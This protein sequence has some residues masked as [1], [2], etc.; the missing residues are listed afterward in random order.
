MALELLRYQ[1]RVK[2]EERKSNKESKMKKI[3]LLQSLVAAIA[4]ATSVLLASSVWAVS[5]LDF[6]MAA[7]T[8]G[9]ISY[10]GGANPLSGVN[11]QVDTITGLSTPLNGGS[12]VACVGCVLSFSTGNFS[13]ANGTTVWNFC[14]GGTISVIGGVDLNGGGLGA[15]DIAAGTTLLSGTVTAGSV[16]AATG[17]FKVSIVSFNDVKDPD[18]AA[19]FGMLGG[20]GI[21]WTGNFNLS[22]NATGA[23]PS[24]FTSTSILSGDI[25]NERVP[26]PEPSTLLLL[27]VGLVGLAFWGRKRVIKSPKA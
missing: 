17:T 15:G 9:T 8:S 27:G 19:F 24:G 18:L 21:P 1:A 26:V 16:T 22:F 13:S 6:D 2:L 23:A 5:Q 12:T 11:I 10:A 20:P 4:F 7:P 25:V 14:G 3:N